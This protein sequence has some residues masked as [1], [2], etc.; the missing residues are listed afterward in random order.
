MT[1]E[2]KV[3]HLASVQKSVAAIQQQIRS[4]RRRR[5][6]WPALVAIWFTSAVVVAYTIITTYSLRETRLQ[7]ALLARQVQADAEA[8]RHTER[9]WVMLEPVRPVVMAHTESFIGL[10]FQYDLYLRNAGRTLAKGIA[11]RALD[12]M[13][14]PALADDAA[15]IRTLQET[16]LADLPELSANHVPSLLA[17]GAVATVPFSLTA[18]G[19]R[20]NALHYLIGRVDYTDTFAANHW[21]TFCLQVANPLGEL[22]YCKGG[23]DTDDLTEG[24]RAAH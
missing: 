19:P 16:R 24:L 23:N 3:K 6:Q 9:A 18:S 17:P 13:A 4:N 5:S 14:G 7:L 15:G 21:M 20:E 8:F 2:Q 10:R 12:T 22:V 1:H 11:V